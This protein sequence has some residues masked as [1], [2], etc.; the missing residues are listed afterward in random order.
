MNE[1][2]ITTRQLN[3]F[4][5]HHCHK[6]WK[7]QCQ[8]IIKYIFFSYIFHGSTCL[9][10]HIDLQTISILSLVWGRKEK[11]AKQDRHMGDRYFVSVYF[12]F[13]FLTSISHEAKGENEYDV[14]TML[15]FFLS[16]C[17]KQY[18]TAPL[19]AKDLLT[20]PP[21]S[22][23]ISIKSLIT[24]IPS[25]HLSVCTS[26]NVYNAN[27]RCIRTSTAVSLTDHKWK[28]WGQIH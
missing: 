20:W 18:I 2:I 22:A 8:I 5:P 15:T 25:V 26:T 7:E 21:A 17:V 19:D 3:L 13:Y 11:K 16:Q 14:L 4:W 1:A 12:L 6:Q 23:Y 28:W 24:I 9:Y 10:V 27:I